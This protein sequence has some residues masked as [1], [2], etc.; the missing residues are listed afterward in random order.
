MLPFSNNPSRKLRISLTKALGKTGPIFP[1]NG[2][3]MPVRERRGAHLFKPNKHQSGMPEVWQVI[4]Y[5]HTFVVEEPRTRRLFLPLS[6]L[7]TLRYGKR[8]RSDSDVFGGNLMCAPRTRRH[9]REF[10]LSKSGEIRLE[11]RAT[12]WQRG[13]EYGDLIPNRL[14]IAARQTNWI[15][16]VMGA[17]SCTST[18]PLPI[19]LGTL[20]SSALFSRRIGTLHRFNHWRNDSSLKYLCRNSSI[21]LIDVK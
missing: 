9:P 18:L 19:R 17:V 14:D 5:K 16:S 15:A 7:H 8:R 21:F 6:N 10:H 12:L 20:L 1:A 3:Q 4:K 2:M 13:C 11:L